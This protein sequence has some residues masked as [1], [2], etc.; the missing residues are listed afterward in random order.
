MAKSKCRLLLDRP[1]E[2]PLGSIDGVGITRYI[3][4]ELFPNYGKK[5]FDRVDEIGSENIHYVLQKE[6]ID[7]VSGCELAIFNDPTVVYGGT[8]AFNGVS[9]TMS[10]ILA[11]GHYHLYLHVLKIPGI[12]VN[13]CFDLCCILERL[14]LMVDYDNFR[15]RIPKM[16]LL[17]IKEITAILLR[18]EIP[19]GLFSDDWFTRFIDVYNRCH[20]RLLTKTYYREQP[21]LRWL[22]Y[23]N[24]DKEF[25]TE[26]TNLFRGCDLQWF[27]PGNSLLHDYPQYAQYE[28]GSY[29]SGLNTGLDEEKM[30]DEAIQYFRNIQSMFSSA[31]NNSYTRLVTNLFP[32]RVIRG[33]NRG[34]RSNRSSRSN[35]SRRRGSN[36]GTRKRRF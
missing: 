23:N 10:N 11:C 14:I 13:A 34:N 17:A 5:F 36:G 16:D 29:K 25:V 22:I 12:K 20:K 6:L 19:D 35:R 21:K 2:Q 30:S 4:L 24:Y 33:R 26:Y 27:S 18:L 31:H 8:N 7:L 3:D 15:L 28:Q 32:D 9:G 1:E